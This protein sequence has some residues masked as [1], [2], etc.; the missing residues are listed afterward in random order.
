[1]INKLTKSKLTER[2]REK[3]QINKTSAQKENITADTEVIQRISRAY[4]KNLGA[5][6]KTKTKT[7][8]QKTLYFTK[9]ESLK[10]LDSFLHKYHLPKF[11]QHKM[12]RL[13][14][15]ITFSETETVIKSPGT[16]GLV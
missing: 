2:K 3:I 7:N 12:S 5:G 10:G 13:N 11:N 1:M 16:D 6:R 4:F 9:L 8:K 14:R 15:S